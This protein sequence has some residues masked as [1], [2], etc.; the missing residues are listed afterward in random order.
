MN[1]SSRFVVATHI[2][3]MVSLTRKEPLKSDLLA[4]S[5]NTNPVVIRRVLGLLQKAKLVVSR[6]GPNGGSVL[7][8]NPGNI[9]LRDIYEA[10]EEEGLF[11][12]HYSEPSQH[13]PIGANIRE[14]LQDVFSEAELKMK[15]VLA[16]KKLNEVMN[17]VMI[18]S[19]M[20]KILPLNLSIKEFQAKYEFRFGKL[21][22]KISQ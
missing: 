20:S 21:I 10:V 15:K 18:D 3:A 9:T 17:D 8:R 19:G 22:E 13:C 12:L 4:K 14:C 2:M 7:A 5:V 1:T 16:G 11:H 6:T